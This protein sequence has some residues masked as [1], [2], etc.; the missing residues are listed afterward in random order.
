MGY[1]TGF[2]GAFRLSQ[3]LDQSQIDLLK[4]VHDQRHEDG[5]DVEYECPGQSDVIVQ[6]RWTTVRRPRKYRGEQDIWGSN[7][8]PSCYC[9]WVLSSDHSDLIWDGG[10]KFYNFVG[11]LKYLIAHFFKPWNV[12]LNGVIDWSGEDPSDSGT[13]VVTNNDITVMFATKHRVPLYPEY[14]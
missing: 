3:A 1:T 2:Q 9:Q 8:Y 13:L 4:K 7:R 14:E 5:Q 6:H 12:S 10:E 11:W